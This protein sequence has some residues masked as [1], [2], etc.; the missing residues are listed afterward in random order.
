MIPV[1]GT[2]RLLEHP[3]TT[4]AGPKRRDAE[5]RQ[6][7]ALL[8]EGE[9]RSQVYLTHPH[10]LARIEPIG[11][12]VE[13][14]QQVVRQAVHVSADLALILGGEHRD[15]SPQLVWVRIGLGQNDAT[16]LFWR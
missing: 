7:R 1:S 3:T 11:L 12:G 9:Q 16:P 10:G 8:G 14:A 4:P 5:R 15:L 6:A 2:G 13:Q